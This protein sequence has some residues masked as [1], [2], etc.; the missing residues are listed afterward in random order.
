MDGMVLM[1]TLE[2]L[3]VNCVISFSTM[4]SV[5]SKNIHSII[6]H[7]VMVGQTYMWLHFG[8]IRLLYDA[9][10]NV[11]SEYSDM[12]LWNKQLQQNLRT[13]KIMPTA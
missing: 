4:M 10:F 13:F 9:N 3:T 5:I 12:Q 6:N 11:P 1:N 7:P 8:P 2:M